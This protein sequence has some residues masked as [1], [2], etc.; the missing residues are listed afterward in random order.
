MNR[1]HRN[2]RIAIGCILPLLMVCVLA[3]S[4]PAADYNRN[5][6]AGVKSVHVQVD[7]GIEGGI[8]GD[9]LQEEI[10][11][12]VADAG[13][14]V[15]SSEEYGKFRMSKGYPFAR[16]DITVQSD[17]LGTGAGAFTLYRIAVVARQKVMLERKAR[18]KIMA[19]TWER[20]IMAVDAGAETIKRQIMEAVDRFISD[21]QSA[22]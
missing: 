21:L 11:R 8:D 22:N 7:R 19:E 14:R 9:R 17:E 18:I 4:A 10:E 3:P 6:L 12:Q 13:I 20:R 2:F 1:R 15:L 16:L 5:L